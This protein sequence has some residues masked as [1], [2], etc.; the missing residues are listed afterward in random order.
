MKAFFL[1]ILLLTG[2]LLVARD[3]RGQDLS[4][5]TV[6]IQLKNV[7]L[8]H[9]LRKIEALTSLPFT[10]KTSD[11]ADY[12]DVSCE[13]TNIPVSH[14]LD[15]LLLN[16]GLG[17]E[18]IN[19]NIII[20]K[21]KAIPHPQP[22]VNVVFDGGVKGR[23]TGTTG[24]AV[25]N[26]TVKVEGSGRAIAADN[27]GMFTLTGLKAGS[28]KLRITAVGYE[29]LVKDIQIKDNE[30]ADYEFILK[31]G[32]GKLDEVVVTALGITRKERSIGYSTQQISGS[33]LTVAKEQNVLGSLG[34]KIAGVQ[35]SG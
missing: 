5:M 12:K 33:N 26:A 24:E 30:I 15:I 10:Y 1:S 21:I 31:E 6:T 9:A 8:K 17:Y 23:V 27:N 22:V 16:T 34:G 29:P 14:V 4:K 2:G 13:G 3:S 18:Q 28:Y 35:V 11:I 25:S 19:S 7:S 20:K 32:N